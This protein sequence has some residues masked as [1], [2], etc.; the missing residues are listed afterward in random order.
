MTRS[1]R[2]TISYAFVAVLSAFLLLWGI[3]AFSPEYP[4]YGVPA[5]LVPNIAAGAMLLLALLGLLRTALAR[6]HEPSAPAQGKTICWLHL[7]RFLVPCFLLMPAMSFFGFVPA[8]VGFLG[9]IQF[10]CGQREPLPLIL[11]AALPVLLVWVIMRYGLGV[12]MP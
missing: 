2:D 10:F 1:Q 4:G 11:V 12:P 8:G 5:S 7:A 6:R 3:P 9:L